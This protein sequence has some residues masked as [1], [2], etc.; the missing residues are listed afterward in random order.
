MH[1][2]R[3]A[4]ARRS[5]SRWSREPRIRCWSHI[6]ERCARLLRARGG[7]GI[8]PAGRGHVHLGDR[9][10]QPGAG[11]D[12]GPSGARPADRPDRR[13]PA[14]AAR[15]RRR[16]DD[17][18]AEALRRRRQVVLRGRR[19]TTPTPERLRWIRALACRAYWTALDGPPGPVHLNFPLREPLVLDGPLP[20]D[21]DADARTGSPWV[22]PRRAPPRRRGPAATAPVRTA[23]DRRRRRHDEPGAA[24]RPRSPR[25]PRI[26]LLADPLS[27]A[28]RGAAAIAHYDLLLRDPALRRRASTRVRV[29]PR[30][31]ADLKAAAQLAGGARRRRADRDRP[32]ARA[33][34][35]PDG[36]V[37]TAPARRARPQPGRAPGA[38][39][40]W[41]DALAG[42]R[43]SA[44]ERRST[45]TLGEE[46]S[47]PLVARAAGR[48]AA[49]GGD[50]VRRL[51]D[52]DPRR[53]GVRAGARRS[54]RGCSPTA[55]PTGSTAP[56]RRAFG[57]A[58]A[59]DGPVVLLIGDVALAHDIGGLLAAP[60]A[61]AAADDRAAQQ[62]RRR[63]LPLPPGGRRGATPSR[64]TS[65]PRT[66]STSRTRPALLR[67]RLRAPARRRRRCATALE[68][69][70]R[71]RRRRRSSR[72]APIARKN[73][74]LHRRVGR[75]GQA[76]RSA[77]EQRQQRL[78]LDLGLGELGR[79]VGVAHD[80]AA[81]VQAGHA[82]AQQ[83]AAQRDA[84]LAVARRVGPAR[85][86]PR[87]S[88]GRAPRA[89]GSARAPRR[90]ARRRRRRRMQE[91]GELDRAE[92][93]GQLRPDR[94]RQVLDV[95]DPHEHRL[96]RR[97][98][99]HG[100]RA[101][102]ARDPARDDR[103]LLAVLVDCAA[104]ARR[105]DR[106][107]PG[108]RCGR[109]EP[110]SAT[111]LARWPSRRTSSS[112]LAPRN[113]A[114]PRP[115]ANTKQ[116]GNASRSTPSTA[117]G[118]WRSGACTSTSRASTTF[119]S[120]PAADPLDGLR[121][122]L[123]EV[124]GR[125][126]AQH[127][128]T[129]RRVR[130]RAAA[131][132]PT[133]SSRQPRADTPRRRSS[134]VSSGATSTFTVSRT[135]PPA[136]RERRARARPA[137]PARSRASVGER[138]AVGREGEAAERDQPG[139]RRALAADRRAAAAASCPPVA[140]RRC[141]KRSAPRRLERAHAAR[142]PRAPSRRGRAARSRTSARRRA[143][144]AATTAVGSTSPGS[145]R[146]DAR[147]HR[148][149]ARARA[150][151]AAASRRLR[152]ESLAS[153]RRSSQR[154]RRRDA[155]RARRTRRS[156]ARSRRARA[157]SRSRPCAPSRSARTAGP[158]ART[159][160]PCRRCR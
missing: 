137:T 70:D 125:H 15:G 1:L 57:V 140:R 154:R 115:T 118:S 110:A 65:R 31:P 93:R 159:R 63:D 37:G 22:E 25:G 30:R 128:R 21:R 157:R 29:P 40:G 155:A 10:G 56:S 97:G 127:A 94:R 92:R 81:G 107:L 143:A 130:D 18:P 58:A 100:V 80:P 43:R 35:I 28:R 11:G 99:P 101:Q 111:V 67:L 112:G 152:A 55:A 87:T 39:P 3:L 79:R 95:G 4:L 98:D 146:G 36:V 20:E 78:E 66:G 96:R 53:R 151:G 83:R 44:R 62:R 134:S 141:A 64:S 90:A 46:L 6:D 102:R 82:P 26:P 38:E 124:R 2:A 54:R 139:T 88:R 106:R 108:R 27:G 133:R 24:T 68:R 122:R 86:A 32:G 76:R 8:G 9:G 123:L 104:A 84:E 131:A 77:G 34:R 47:E 16:P 75:R 14:G 48:V 105:G 121:D 51:L 126:R 12:R 148:R 117:A 150:S 149:A 132:A 120:S 50:A 144:S 114:S 7:Q 145:Q 160:R 45:S 142:A 85:P 73:P 153:G 23:G 138:A 60:A 109:V 42:R 129:R 59:G 158:A 91:A 41:L 33:G 49:P 19:R 136:A 72:S 5:C 89:P 119:S 52:A 113:V 61:R 156:S 74:A 135:V 17:R 71:E 69:V 103:V 13:P 147:Q 116:D